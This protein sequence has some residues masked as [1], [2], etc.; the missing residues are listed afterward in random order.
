MGS[1]FYVMTELMYLKC[2]I[3]VC[4]YIIY[5]ADVNLHT[6]PCP[7]VDISLLR[8]YVVSWPEVGYSA[9]GNKVKQTHRTVEGNLMSSYMY[10]S[11]YLKDLWDSSGYKADLCDT[12]I[13]SHAWT[14][15]KWHIFHYNMD[16]SL[17]ISYTNWHVWKIGVLPQ[18]QYLDLQPDT[19]DRVCIQDVWNTFL[20]ITGCTKQQFS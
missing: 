4:M 20:I 12:S 15:N 1:H 13:R 3:V 17:G 5:V 6:P 18:T 2:C 14:N 9:L 11:I 8:L 7:L 10:Y 19:S 16:G